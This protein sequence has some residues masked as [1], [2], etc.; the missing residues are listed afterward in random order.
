MSIIDQLYAGYDSFFDSEKKIASYILDHPQDVINMTI[1]ELAAACGTS[2]ASISRFCRKLELDSFHHLKIN[3]A[4]AEADQLT[5]PLEAEKISQDHVAESLQTILNNKIAELTA[6]IKN[7]D[8]DVLVQCLQAIEHAGRVHVAAVGNTIP[9][10]MD[11]A[12]KF[13]EIGIPT[14]TSSVWET[15]VSY[16]YTLQKGDVLIAISN[17]GESSKVA[18]MVN[19]ANDRGAVTIG[20]TNNLHSTVG[21]SVDHHIQTST[22]E[23]LFLNEFYFSRISAST[24]IEILYLFLVSAEKDS[25]NRIRANEEIYADQKK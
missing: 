10:A 6:T 14:S 1:K 19:I 3:L 4:K 17:S 7:I 21:K 2:E 25:Y 20:I 18:D 22:R 23:K 11:C 24:V 12:F 13:N 9:V 15:Q 5:V 8:A 16:T